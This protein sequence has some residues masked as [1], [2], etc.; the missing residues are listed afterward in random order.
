M[1]EPT[2]YRLEPVPIILQEDKR[3]MVGLSPMPLQQKRTEHY[4]HTK[5]NLCANL[6]APT[7]GCHRSRRRPWV[8]LHPLRSEACT[9][10]RSNFKHAGVVDGITCMTVLHT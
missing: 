4:W 9:Q 5:H 8:S 10:H 7:L 1:H 6:P 2:E 3:I